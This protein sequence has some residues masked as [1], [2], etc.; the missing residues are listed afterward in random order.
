MPSDVVCLEEKDEGTGSKAHF[1]KDGAP[2]HDDSAPLPR[3][4]V[5]SSEI[6]GGKDERSFI[7]L[8]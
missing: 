2:A 4:G 3:D 6:G 7:Q 5:H 1:P 8:L